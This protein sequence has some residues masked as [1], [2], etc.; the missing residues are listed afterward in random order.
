MENEEKAINSENPTEEAIIEG[1]FAEENQNNPKPKRTKKEIRTLIT[2]SC[3]F[4]ALV[5]I[6][7]VTLVAGY[8]APTSSTLPTT[9]WS[10]TSQGYY[11]KDKLLIKSF[12]LD[13]ISLENDGGFYS[14]ASIK[15]NTDAHYMVLPSSSS[16]TSIIYTNIF[17]EGNNLFGNDGSEDNIEEIYFP[18]LYYRIGAYSFSDLASLTKISFAGSS[19][20]TLTI[21]EGAFTSCPNLTTIELPTNISS[22]GAG[23]FNS[24]SL[25]TINY[26][27]TMTS[28]NN[29]NYDW[30]FAQNLTIN[31][32]DGTIVIE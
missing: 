29:L 15:G 18:K 31:C 2:V 23:A 21:G 16:G 27:G 22:I 11:D 24:E 12:S 8:N 32:S 13:D 19:T 14:V 1:E 6:T 10:S 26:K 20:G 25:S 4:G 28:F 5:A 17:T 30:S 9:N 3:L 7:T